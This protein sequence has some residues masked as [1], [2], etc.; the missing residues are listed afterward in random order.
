[1]FGFGKKK[2][3]DR[4][5]GGILVE[6]GMFQSW[7]LDNR[8]VDLGAVILEHIIKKILDRENVKYSDDEVTGLKF[9]ALSNME[10]EQLRDFRRKTNF[11]SNV[12]G[13]CKSINLPSEFYTPTR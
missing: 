12:A 5:T 7:T 13:F 2:L 6:L 4:L 9:M 8:G 10:W 11:D 1:M 3:D